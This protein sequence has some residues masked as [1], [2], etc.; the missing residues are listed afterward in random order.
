MHLNI[1]PGRLF[2]PKKKVD[3]LD[4]G[5]AR[6][7]YQELPLVHFVDTEAPIL[8]VRLVPVQARARRSNRLIPILVLLCMIGT[9]TIF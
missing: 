4:L 8:A 7:V 9:V 5:T 3:M 6:D 2:W 1:I